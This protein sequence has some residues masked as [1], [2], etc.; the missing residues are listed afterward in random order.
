VAVVKSSME[1]CSSRLIDAGIYSC[2]AANNIGN[3][4]FTFTLTVKTER[5]RILVLLY[6]H[7]ARF[8]I[9]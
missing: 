6:V 1:I 7:R 8:V 3:D 5:G 2:T 9:V 4:S